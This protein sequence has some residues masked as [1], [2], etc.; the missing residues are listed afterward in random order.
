SLAR[1]QRIA[2]LD[3]T[4][5]DEYDGY[6]SCAAFLVH[7]CGMGSGEANRQ[8]FLARAL[9]QVPY[10]VKLTA[11]GRLSVNQ[12]EMLAH[13]Q[14]RHPDP[15]AADEPTLAEAATDLTAADTRRLID[16]WCQAHDEPDDK[17]R[18]P[19]QTFLS[20]TLGGRGRLD[21]DLDPEDYSLLAAALDTLI[22]E[23]VQTTPKKDLAPMPQL[24]AEA[25]A[26]MARR[27]LDSP[28]TPTDHGNRP[29]LAVVI[30]WEVLTGR[31]RDGIS[32]FLDGTILTPEAAQRLACDANVCRLLTG[33]DGE[34][35]D[36]GRTRR[37]VSPAQWKALRIRDRH[38]QWAGCWR[39]WSWTDAHHIEHWVIHDG[40]TDLNKLVL[41]CRHHHTLVHEGGWTLTGTPGHLIFT[42]PDGTILNNGPP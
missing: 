32:E 13:A 24:R 39:P 42:R 3:E 5:G 37:T 15:Y 19:S 1:L 35:L 36:L 14:N 29:H 38:C 6:T 26:E 25:L 7:R 8:V 31:H 20:R 4:G 33:P 2:V 17:E 28:D 30:D 12:L 10:A 34:I 16:Y 40:P 9:A 27:H 41:L 11:A 18:E 23:M 22:T 21:G